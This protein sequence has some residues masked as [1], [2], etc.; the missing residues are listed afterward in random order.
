MNLPLWFEQMRMAL[1]M[2]NEREFSEFGGKDNR[3]LPPIEP[4]LIGEVEQ[5]LGRKLPAS[6]RAFYA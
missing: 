2:L 3:L 1:E 4:S 5:T 6:V